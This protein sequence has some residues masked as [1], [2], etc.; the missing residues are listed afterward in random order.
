MEK[1][2][3]NNQNES[4]DPSSLLDFTSNVVLAPIQYSLKIYINL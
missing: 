2:N 1:N 3:K 4:D